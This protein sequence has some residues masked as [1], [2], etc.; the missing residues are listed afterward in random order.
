M[1]MIGLVGTNAGHACKVRAY[2][3]VLAHRCAHLHAAMFVASRG[4]LDGNKIQ[5]NDRV[6]LTLNVS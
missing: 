4:F 1:H 6:K 3:V 2:A 5:F